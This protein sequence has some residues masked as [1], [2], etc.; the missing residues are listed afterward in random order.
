MRAYFCDDFRSI[1]LQR[2][3][4]KL[5]IEKLILIDFRFFFFSFSTYQYLKGK[6]SNFSFNKSEFDHSEITLKHALEH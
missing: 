2:I 1:T 6:K 3:T 5:K 4:S